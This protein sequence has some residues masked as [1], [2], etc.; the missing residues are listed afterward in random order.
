MALSEQ[1]AAARYEEATATYGAALERLARAY[2]PDPELRRDLMQ[3]IHIALWR[4]LATFDGRCS[5]RTWVYRVAHNTA[6]SQAFRRR[7]RTAGAPQFVSLDELAMMPAYDYGAA[8]GIDDEADRQRALERMFTLIQALAPLD[9]QVILLYL[10]DLDAAAIGEVTGL[11]AGNVA[12]KVHRIKKILSQR[13]HEG[14]R[15]GR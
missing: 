9:R 1:E 5:L 15:H 10:E 12:T 2:E 6:T 3:E 7:P 4:S 8:D 14:A 13:F 11:S